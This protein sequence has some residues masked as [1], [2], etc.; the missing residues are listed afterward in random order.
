MSEAGEVVLHLA[1]EAWDVFSSLAPKAWRYWIHGNPGTTFGSILLLSLATMGVD[2]GTGGRWRRY[3]SRAALTDVLYAVFYLA[4]FYAVL[5]LIPLRLLDGLADRHLGFLKIDLIEPW[6]VWL[7]FLVFT[8]LLDGVQYGQHRLM[9]VNRVL[10][11]FHCIH[12]SAGQ[13][14]PFT[15]FRFHFV[16]MAV[17]SVVKIVPVLI[18]GA[19]AW[20]G[21]R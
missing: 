5:V 20:C 14:T 13:L 18:L 16:D 11:G 8:V 10:W 2:L 12:H 15:K 7:Q 1:H 4:G 17:F 19:P 9:H 21:R 6:P 3:F